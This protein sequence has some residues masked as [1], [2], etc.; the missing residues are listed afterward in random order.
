MHAK[1][2]VHVTLYAI[3]QVTMHVFVPVTVHVLVYMT[4]GQGMTNHQFPGGNGA[5]PTSGRR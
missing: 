1:A 5:A 4:V 2:C 3:V